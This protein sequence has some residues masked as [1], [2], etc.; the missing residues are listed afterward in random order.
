MNKVRAWMSE[1]QDL[2]V[3]LVSIFI[4]YAVAFGEALSDPVFLYS[5]L[6]VAAVV[7]LGVLY[8]CLS[9]FWEPRLNSSSPT[10]RV[11]G[12]FMVQLA[13]AAAIQ[14]IFRNP[15]GIW[16]ISMP[17]VGTAVAHLSP[18][19]RW[20]VYLAVLA[21]MAG[22][23]WVRYGPG[24]ALS[25]GFSF[26]PAILFVAIFVR[27][28]MNEGEARQRAEQLTA[29]LE[30]AN[31]QLAEYATQAEELATSKERNRL[32]R[33]IHDNLGHY[34]TVINVQLEAARLLQSTNPERALEALHK[35]QTL[36][37]EGLAAVRHSV[38]ALRESPLGD[39]PLPE[40][41]AA[42]VAETRTAGLVAELDVRGRPRR[43]EAN[44][45]LTLYRAVQEGRTN[46]R[47]HA[48]ASRVDLTLDYD[49]PA[50][51]RLVVQ[52]NG[53]GSAAGLNGGFGLLGVR[54]RVELLGGRVDTDSGPGRGFRLMVV[55][56]G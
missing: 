24:A 12:Y 1:R 39:R 37:Q 52:D 22:P 25:V 41:I 29:E 21:S 36:A 34:L 6:E 23:V 10:W 30:A 13:L 35:A 8:L 16:L 9:L 28:L 20:P 17:L 31:R 32:A 4:G 26:A 51:V 11:A 19:W 40:A 3:T 45:E 54:E 44:A 47:T 56:P 5:P 15:A 38:A 46:V 50:G 2:V 14:A 43:L 49:D 42:L 48:R 18:L 7:G 27:L 55:V 53:V 33:E